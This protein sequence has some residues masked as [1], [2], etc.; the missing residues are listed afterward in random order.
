MLICGSV[1]LS[2]QNEAVEV[3]KETE[4]ARLLKRPARILKDRFPVTRLIDMEYQTY[5][6]YDFS[7]KLFKKDY[8]DGQVKERQYFRLSTNVPVVKK[9]KWAITASMLYKYESFDIQKS[10]FQNY[11]PMD[12]FRIK[13]NHFF[14]GGVGF[15]YYSKLF[16]KTVIYNATTGFDGSNKQF[17][18]G[19]K[20]MGNAVMVL[21][22][23]QKSI[24]SIGVVTMYNTNSITPFVP[25]F[26][27]LLQLGDGW[28]LDL[29]LPQRVYFIKAAGKDGRLT[30]GSDLRSNLSYVYPGIEG[31]DKSYYYREIQLRTSAMYEHKFKSFILYSRMGL[32]NVLDGKLIKT[33]QTSSKHI[34]SVKSNPSFYFNVGV[35]FNP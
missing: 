15:T 17:F 32:I 8:Q 12:L 29:T 23:S 20:L 16:G 28:A 21:N 27:Y 4:Q 3:Q 10:T 9:Q 6:A 24:M 35:S 31:F 5:S 7:S 1:E 18:E 34:M 25:V 26:V 11:Q 33:G 30:L 22:A 14:M 13:D 2:A 19:F